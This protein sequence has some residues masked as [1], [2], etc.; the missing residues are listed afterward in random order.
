MYP[1]IDALF[2][3]DYPEDRLL[4]LRGILSADQLRNPNTRDFKGDNLRRVIKHG[5]ATLTTIGNLSG[6]ESYVCHYSGIGMHDSV[7]VAI[8]PCGGD[9][10]PFSRDGDS[11][12][13]IV[14]ALGRFVALLTGGTGPT[15]LVDITFGTPMYWLWDVI[16]EKFPGAN[17]FFDKEDDCVHLFCPIFSYR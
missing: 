15:D 5:L 12:S 17:L 14:D 11:G 4:K 1:Y 13:I 6:F 3:F 9:S 8:Y 16:Q 7:E 2:E 10:G